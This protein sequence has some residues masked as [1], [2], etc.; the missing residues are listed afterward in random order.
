MESIQ[1]FSELVKRCRGIICIHGKSAAGKTTLAKELGTA[2]GYPIFH[3]DS[4][5]RH[6]FS[7]SLYVLMADLEERNERNCIIEGIQV[8]RLLRRGF[9]CDLIIEVVCSEESRERRYH[10]RGHQAKL[11]NLGNFDVLLG[12]IWRECVVTCPVL[13]YSTG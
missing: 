3:T 6:G 4:Y 10:E 13:R 1:T 12:R 7:Q 9:K 5:M 2:I 8:P 11:H